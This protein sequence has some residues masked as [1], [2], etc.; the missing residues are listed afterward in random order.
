MASFVT[1]KFAKTVMVS[2]VILTGLSACNPYIKT[3]QPF[4]IQHKIH[5]AETVERLEV[6]IR[7]TGMNLSARD[8]GAMRQFISLYG[9]EGDGAMFLN[10]PSNSASSN[11]MRQAKA[12]IQNLLME[13]GMAGAPVQSGQYS[14]AQ[15]ASAPLV[16]SFRRLAVVPED[17]IQ[18]QN[19]TRTYNNQAYD[20][21]GCAG[22]SNF[23]VLTGD[24][25]QLLEPYPVDK[26]I[27]DR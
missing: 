11:G 7:P 8:R 17:C 14:A 26:R 3:V 10:I 12:E 24:P 4:D 15:G 21:F 20:N 6:Y 25:K 27:G 16:L 13:A 22:L 2:A 23:A 9:Q 19:I 1:S 5:V 18:N